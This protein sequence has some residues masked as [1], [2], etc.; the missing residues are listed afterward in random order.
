MS[1]FLERQRLDDI[2]NPDILH[3]GIDEDE[4]DESLAHYASRPSKSHKG[5]IQTIEWDE[6]LE[7]I[8]QQKE[9]AD[10]NRGKPLFP[11]FPSSFY[12]CICLSC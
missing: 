3:K 5:K 10:A 8:R 4:I 12:V 1:S 11:I 7:S 9:I 2:D 6:D